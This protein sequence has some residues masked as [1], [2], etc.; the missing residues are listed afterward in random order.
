MKTKVDGEAT[1]KPE[2]VWWGDAT[3]KATTVRLFVDVKVEGPVDTAR[4]DDWARTVSEE[5]GER[6][7]PADPV[8]AYSSGGWE[9]R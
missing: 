2:K 8:T 5:F 3:K 9:R 1:K 4:L 7:H 6:L